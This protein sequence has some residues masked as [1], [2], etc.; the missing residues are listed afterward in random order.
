MLYNKRSGFSLIEI[1]VAITIVAIMTAGAFGLFRYVERAK[2]TRAETG[3]RGVQLALNTFQGDT[4][5][6]PMTLL[7][8]VTKPGDAV[9]AK[10]W[11]GPYLDEKDLEDSWKHSFAYQVNPKN[12]AR[13]YEL[14]SWG[15]N[16]EGS[17]PDEWIDVWNS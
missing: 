14:Y 12:S 4:G 15:A 7:D 11:R 8:M 16:G 6:W 5:S 2:R 13:P 9:I 1:L 17:A 3:L 10:R